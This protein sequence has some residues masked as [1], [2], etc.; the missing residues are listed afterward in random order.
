M[1]SIKKIKRKK[2]DLEDLE[3][4]IFIVVL[5]VFLSNAFIMCHSNIASC[6]Q[7]CLGDFSSQYQLF[8]IKSA[9]VKISY[10][11][12]FAFLGKAEEKA[13]GLG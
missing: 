4:K 9:S 13:H 12:E 5:L 11:E 3:I 6:F 8:V 2:S 7:F 1:C 10:W